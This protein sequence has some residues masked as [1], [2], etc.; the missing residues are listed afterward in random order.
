VFEKNDAPVPAL[1]KKILIADDHPDT[2]E[3]AAELLRACGYEVFTVFNGQQAVE[4][5]FELQPAVIILDINMPI[6]DGYDA[7]TALRQKP[8]PGRPPILIAHTARA[9]PAD[10]RRALEAGFDHHLPKPTW[11][12]IALIDS[13]FQ[14]DE[15]EPH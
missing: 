6:M 4:A 10:V 14:A 12:L 5:A 1:P 11:G 13:L 15:E 7:A 2:A 8:P 3:T 9:A